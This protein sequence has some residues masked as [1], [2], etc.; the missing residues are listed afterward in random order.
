MPPPSPSPDPASAAV[1]RYTPDG[2]PLDAAERTPA[3]LTRALV[4]VGGELGFAR[5]GVTTAE[6]LEAA[7]AHLEAF[8]AAGYA[9]TMAYLERLPRHDP[10][11]LLPEARS[12]VVVAAAHGVRDLVPL[13]SR[14]GRLLGSVARYARGADYHGVLR[15]LLSELAARLATLAGRPLLARVCVDT[16]PLL[17]RAL[18]A[19][20]GIGFAAKSGMVIAPGLGSYFL[21]GELVTDL[22]L[23]PST[24]IRAGCGSCRACLDACPTRAFVGPQVLDARRC[25]AYLTIESSAPI[26]R[27]LRSAI[28]QRVFGCDVCQEVCPYNAAGRE[29]NGPLPA[30]PEL[31]TLDLVGLLELGSSG[32]RRLV[33]GSALRRASLRMLQRNAAVA[34]GNSDDPR[35]VPALERALANNPSPLVRGHAAWALGALCRH[36]TPTTRGALERAALGDSD[37]FVRAEAT[38]ALEISAAPL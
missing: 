20:A 18:A 12:V 29:P 22:E 2:P 24:A 35:G 23:E 3:G 9:G 28:G 36:A 32:Y 34:L 10:R 37:A 11:T 31:T 25:I 7:R 17:E 5:V 21:L 33:Q 26:P 38:A 8:L 1:H 13:R 15:G 14:D 4:T 16:A 6:P 30:R 27:E 19:R